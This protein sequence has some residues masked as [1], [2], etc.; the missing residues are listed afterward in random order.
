MSSPRF[1]LPRFA[2]CTPG[3]LDSCVRAVATAADLDEVIPSLS[4]HHVALVARDVLEVLEAGDLGQRDPLGGDWLRTIVAEARLQEADRLQRRG[5]REGSMAAWARAGE[6]LEEV[7]SSSD[8]SAVLWYED[9]YR[10]VVQALLLR[11]DPLALVRQ[12]ECIGEQFARSE[13]P[14]LAAEMRD[15]ALVHLELGEH[16]EG[17]CL[18]AALQR[19][20]PSDPWVYNAVALNLPRLGFPSLGRLAA[21]RGLELIRRGDDRERLAQQLSDLLHGADRS[22]QR[23]EVPKDAVEELRDALHTPFDA[24]GSESLRELALRLV[25]ELATARVKQL[26]PMPTADELADIGTR[27][28]PFLR[29][30]STSATPVAKRPELEPSRTVTRSAPKVGRNELCS[31]GS[32]KKFKKCCED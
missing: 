12:R 10:E 5:D 1:L 2:G 29:A 6:I 24:K 22:E 23:S 7:V 14:N 13:S 32:G 31:C 4:A 16:R 9:I 11:R 30:G 8:R 28:L 27:L 25:P 21:E 18:M 3:V 17:L 26:P 19:R 15:L 20:D